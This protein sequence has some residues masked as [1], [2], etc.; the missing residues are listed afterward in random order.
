MQCHACSGPLC[1]L[2]VLGKLAHLVCRHCGLQWSVD[3]DE[4][5][6]E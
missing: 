5:D 2:G 4:L 3:A 1:L 6:Q